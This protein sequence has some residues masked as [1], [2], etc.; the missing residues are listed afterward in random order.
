VAE[1]GFTVFDTGGA[2]LLVTAERLPLLELDAG[3]EARDVRDGYARRIAC[4]R[5]AAILD[6][7]HE[8][9]PDVLVCDEMDFGAF[10]VAEHLGLP[11]AS[12]VCIGTGSLITPELVAEPLNELRAAYGLAADPK[13]RMLSRYLVLSP[14]PPSYR[15]PAFPLPPT[16][17]PLRPTA[18]DA[19]ADD[20]ALP[21]LARPSERPVVYF[22]L[23]TIFNL[24]SGDLF[25]RVLTGLRE[26]P[27]GVVATVGRE[28]DPQVLGPQ[29]ADVRIERYVPQSLLL[30]RCS[31]VVSHAGSGS[32]VGALAHGLPMVLIPIGADQPLNAARCAQLGVALVLDA[33]RATPADV[34]EA[35][36]IVLANPGY[37]ENAKRISD[38]IA[39]LPP[40][41][42]AVALLERLAAEKRPVPSA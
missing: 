3:R 22:T 31:M 37:R 27:V 32:V 29:P 26:L 11:Y 38:E 36:S 24:E 28:L 13:V 34:R 18:A 16:G 20:G 1:A 21:W 39:A 12:V 9:R 4:E 14:F 10:V 7:C 35:A 33:L 41:E 42:H 30:P 23:G 8:W 19:P 2:S 6:L 17:H 15:D 40:P 25:E 5:A